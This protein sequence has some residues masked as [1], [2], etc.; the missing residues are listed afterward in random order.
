MR[1]RSLET[2]S[3]LDLFEHERSFVRRRVIGNTADKPTL[4]VLPDG[5]A[6]IESY[7]GFA[8]TLAPRFDIVL[9]EPP[10]TG[11]SFPKSE[12]ALEFEEIIPEYLA[13]L[14]IAQTGSFQ[15]EQEWFDDVLDS[16]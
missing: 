13:G 8:E 4:V 16:D 14:I 15:A 6:T 11:F 3:G 10:G 12:K 7:D 5:P 1:E 2:R 9:L